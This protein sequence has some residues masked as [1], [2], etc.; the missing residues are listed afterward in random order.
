MYVFLFLYDIHN[1]SF[2]KFAVLT[3]LV[4]RFIFQRS[5]HNF[6]LISCNLHRFKLKTERVFLGLGMARGDK[7][8][9]N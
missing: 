2:F 9:E 3:I 8:L 1:I 6:E 7:Q 5:P 4:S